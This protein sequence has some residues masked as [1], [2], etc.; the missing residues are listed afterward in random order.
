MENIRKL[1]ITVCFLF[2]FKLTF[3]APLTSISIILTL[4]GYCFV[5]LFFVLRVLGFCQG[6]ESYV[7]ERNQDFSWIRW[8]ACEEAWDHRM[9]SWTVSSASFLPSFCVAQGGHQA[10]GRGQTVVVFNLG[11][12]DRSQSRLW[13]W[14]RCNYVSSDVVH[15][16]RNVSLR[17]IAPVA[18]ECL[19]RVFKI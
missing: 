14:T 11:W 16:F 5:C 2:C 7:E 9:P 4:E 18:M 3:S 19:K 1:G 8:V 15:L 13:T 10:K 6:W 17:S 12:H